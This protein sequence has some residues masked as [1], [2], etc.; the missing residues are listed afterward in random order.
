MYRVYLDL[1]GCLQCL[2]SRESCV[3]QLS[4]L[5]LDESAFFVC[6]PGFDN[7]MC[8]LQ[9]SSLRFSDFVCIHAWME[10]VSSVNIVVI[11]IL[12]ILSCLVY[13]GLV[14]LHISCV[15]VYVDQWTANTC[16]NQLFCVYILGEIL[17]HV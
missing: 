14:V 9:Q 3:D 16:A 2:Y 6:T 4:S 7:L 17:F 10:I 8:V 15:V 11:C 1:L 12:C 13:I 5:R